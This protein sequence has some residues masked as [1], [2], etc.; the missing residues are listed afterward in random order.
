MVSLF[1]AWVTGFIMARI[2]IAGCGDI[3]A[4]AARRLVYYGH[5]VVGLKRHPPQYDDKL[6][7]IKCDLTSRSDIEALDTD[8]DLVI[9]ILT[10]DDRSEQS[11]SKAFELAV[12]NLLKRFS[13]NGGDARF[14]FISS[15]SVYGQAHG[16]WVDEQS[17]TEPE[18][19][20]GQIILQAEKAFLSQGD[21]CVIRFSGIYGRNRS[22][23]LDTVR[24]GGE[25]QYEPPYYT[26]RIHRDDCVEIIRFIA[27]RMLA[28][29]PVDSLYLASDDDPAP[30]WDVFNYLARMLDVAPPGKAIL[31]HDADQNKRCRNARLKQLGYEFSYTSYREGYEFIDSVNG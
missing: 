12:N 7:Y 8:F 3:G 31:P 21:N 29:E 27:N 17:A 24:K 15:T 11:Y 9:F 2:L 13:Q 14:I 28:G 20:T 4:A 26:N 16:E 22:R 6:Q 25:V 19:I 30:K 1:K 10:P 23:L 5:E 18:T